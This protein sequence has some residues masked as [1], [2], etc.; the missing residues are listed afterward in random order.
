MSVAAKDGPYS[1]GGK[2][3][4]RNDRGNSVKEL[5][6]EKD[7]HKTIPYLADMNLLN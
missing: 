2:L 5:E 3:G 1:K 6:K 7:P 4:E